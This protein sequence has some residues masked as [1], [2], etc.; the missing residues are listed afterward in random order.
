MNRGKTLSF[1]GLLFAACVF[2]SCSGPKMP[3]TTNCNQQ[4]TASVSATM[5]TV[6]L[7]PPPGTNILSFAVTITGMS[8]TPSGGGSAVNLTLPATSITVDLMRLQSDSALLGQA[9]ADRKSTR[10]NSS[11]TVISYA[12]FC[13]KKKKNS[14]HQHLIFQESDT[15]AYGY[16]PI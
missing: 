14:E 4:G 9:L 16:P 5:A 8:L 2:T 13:L 15:R 10:L 12:V 6:P 11:H 7:A 3:C 1:A